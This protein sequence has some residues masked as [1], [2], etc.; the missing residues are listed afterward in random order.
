MRALYLEPRMVKTWKSRLECANM[1]T[2]KQA[3]LFWI[4][5]LAVR[6]L[7]SHHYSFYV[8]PS[9]VS[10]AERCKRMTRNAHSS[11]FPHTD[12]NTQCRNPSDSPS[13]FW[14]QTC[15]HW[16]TPTLEAKS[17]ALYKLQ[18]ALQVKASS[19]KHANNP[20]AEMSTRQAV[21][22]TQVCT[23]P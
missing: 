6:C 23:R 7:N 19:P 14:L 17:G 12:L 1:L 2:A 18:F 13:K 21:L 9:T 10:L 16:K 5:H 15:W 22:R 3:E 8:R 4:A 20:F 11:A